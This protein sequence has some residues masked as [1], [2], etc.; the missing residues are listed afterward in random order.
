MKGVS[1]IND[2]EELKQA[3][4]ERSLSGRTVWEKRCTRP[5]KKKA[6]P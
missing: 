3:E 2:M 5:L 4:K 6:L 1:V